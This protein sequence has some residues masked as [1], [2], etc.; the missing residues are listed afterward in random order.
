MRYGHSQTFS[1]GHVARSLIL[2]FKILSPV[3]MA[4]RFREAGGPGCR[5]TDQATVKRDAK[6]LER[7]GLA[8]FLRVKVCLIEPNNTSNSHPHVM[9][10]Q[11]SGPTIMRSQMFIAPAS[12]RL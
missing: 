3:E 7:K 9:R 2:R 10:I 5:N 12:L 6:V 11:I 1:H 8:Q 4:E